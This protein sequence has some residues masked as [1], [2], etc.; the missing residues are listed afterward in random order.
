ME[1][2]V[3]VII[4]VLLCVRQCIPRIYAEIKNG[5]LRQPSAEQDSAVANLLQV[6][7][8]LWLITILNV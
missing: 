2:S 7:K 8:F 6:Q 5:N 3:S 4:G 1:K